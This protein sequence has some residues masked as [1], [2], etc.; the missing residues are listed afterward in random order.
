[1]PSWGRFRAAAA[2]AALLALGAC[3]ERPTFSPDQSRAALEGFLGAPDL[4]RRLPWCAAYLREALGAQ[5]A[6][7]A[8]PQLVPGSLQV[9]EVVRDRRRVHVDATWRERVGDDERPGPACYCGKTGCLETWLSGPGLVRDA[10]APDG[11][12][13]TAADIARLD[14]RAARR[15]LEDLLDLDPDDPR[16]HDRLGWL[17]LREARL[18]DAEQAFA[19][20]VALDPEG[21]GPLASLGAL[22]ERQGRLDESVELI[23]RS[24][25]RESTVTGWANLGSLLARMGRPAEAGLALEEA[26]RLDPDHPGALLFLAEHLR[27]QGD[28]ARCDQAARHAWQAR[29][30]MEP[31][32]RLRLAGVRAACAFATGAE[33]EGRDLRA[34]LR[35]EAPGSATARDLEAFLDRI[36]VPPER[37]E[38]VPA[39][40]P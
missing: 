21:A 15:A 18:D 40:G 13:L 33:R 16:V 2:L 7:E 23:R 6:G 24:L 32:A 22:R 28:Y 19:R 1:M 12:P 34:G 29:Q 25:S 11:P 3:A 38:P 17:A 37:R 9:H 20:A 36:G 26:L 30:A 27:D 10:R 4:T 5:A 39:A 14:V 31:F 35:A 8:W